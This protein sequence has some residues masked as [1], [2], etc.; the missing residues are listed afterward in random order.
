MDKTLIERLEASDIRA[1]S[2]RQ[3]WCHHIL[4]SG[5]N[6][7]NRDWPTRYRGWFL[8]HAGKAWDGGRPEDPEI[9]EAPRGG[10]VGAARITNCVTYMDSNWFF[11]RYGFVL[12]DPTTT[13]LIPC[14]GALGFFRPDSEVLTSVIA[15]LKAKEADHE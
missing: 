4:Y 12:A 15:A 14:T 10:I 13:P 11:G 8:I 6:V 3:P 9:R 2:I 5:K 7:E 1:L